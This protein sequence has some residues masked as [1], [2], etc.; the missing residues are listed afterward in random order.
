MHAP[1]RTEMRLL[2]RERELAVISSCVAAARAGEGATVVVEGPGGIGKTELLRAAVREAH[3][4]GLTVVSARASELERAFAFGVARQLLEPVAT[5]AGGAAVLTGAAALA[6]P[7]FELA[8]T[9][10]GERSLSVLHGLYWLCA[11]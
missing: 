9:G 5:G 2:D 1:A 6:R 7:V 10:G 4:E 8:E 11:N 3:A